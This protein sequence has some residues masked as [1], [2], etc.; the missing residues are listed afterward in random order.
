MD[1]NI[2]VW[3]KCL[4]RSEVFNGKLENELAE[5]AAMKIISG[6]KPPYSKYKLLTKDEISDAVVVDGSL[7]HEI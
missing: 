6:Y 1:G 3:T 4:P 7:I 5:N 2:I